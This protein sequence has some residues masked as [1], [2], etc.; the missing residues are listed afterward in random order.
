MTT[1]FLET[2][3]CARAMSTRNAGAAKLTVNAATPPRMNSRRVTLVAMFVPLDELILAG[4]GD[5]TRQ[6][7]GFGVHLRVRACPRPAGVQIVEKLVHFRRLV[8]RGR[9][10][11]QH[12]VQHTLRL[13]TVRRAERSRKV[14]FLIRSQRGCKV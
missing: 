10:P 14:E 8:R 4:P 3:P 6:A 9:Q 1:R 5:Q 11:L 7:C 12:R 2:A 13:C